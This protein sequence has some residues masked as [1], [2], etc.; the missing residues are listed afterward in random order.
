MNLMQTKLEQTFKDYL[1]L[2]NYIQEDSKSI[3]K[4]KKE[5]QDEA[6]LLDTIEDQAE[7]YFDKL[8]Y[9]SLLQLDLIEKQKELYYLIQ[10]YKDLVEIPKDLLDEFT[11]YKVNTVFTV[12]AGEKKIIN[13]E[14]YNSYKK[15]SIDYSVQLDN[16]NK[17]IQERGAN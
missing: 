9:K 12:L 11:D 4:I 2:K 17:I 10:A 13:Q 16:Y 8:G 6:L 5:L 15:Q 1:E 7:I 3:E 14:L